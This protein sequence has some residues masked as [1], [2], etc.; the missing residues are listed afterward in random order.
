MTRNIDPLVPDVLQPGLAVVFCGTALGRESFRQ[1]AYYAHPGNRF[2]RTL[3]NVGLTP[4][5][6]LPKE[7]P[8]VT[9]FGIGLTDVCKTSYGNDIDILAPQFDPLATREKILRYQPRL[10]AFTS[11]KAASVFSGTQTGTIEYGVQPESAG[12][13]RLYV[14]PSPSGSGSKYW[15]ASYWQMLAELVKNIQQ[16]KA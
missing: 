16:K 13:T 9:R 6:I 1:R 2:W 8:I 14:L 12:S 15:D 7:Y 3:H 10:L 11:K 5:Q 4:Y